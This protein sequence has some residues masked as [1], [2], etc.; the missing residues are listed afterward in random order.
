MSRRWLNELVVWE[1]DAATFLMLLDAQGHT[2]IR[3]SPDP[4]AVPES[5]GD[6]VWVGL[7]V[8]LMFGCGASSA[9]F[10]YQVLQPVLVW[11]G[12]GT[13]FV[14]AI[15]AIILLPRI[16]LKRIKNG[17]RIKA[18]DGPHE[19]GISMTHLRVGHEVTPIAG[20]GAYIIDRHPAILVFYECAYRFPSGPYVPYN[21][22]PEFVGYNE[23]YIPI[24]S[25]KGAE[26]R[27][28]ASRLNQY[29]PRIRGL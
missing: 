4:L 23:I 25:G 13:L 1:L 14:S 24:P 6:R 19:V 8:L 11:V 9:F 17:K 20:L 18:A 21:T 22:P 29:T 7:C 16:I 2:R 12:L 10:V 28:I 15:I 27:D 26:A 5:V 3:F